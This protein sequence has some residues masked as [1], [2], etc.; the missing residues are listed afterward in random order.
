MSLNPFPNALS[1]LA[2]CFYAIKVLEMLTLLFIDAMICVIIE[3]LKFL[4]SSESK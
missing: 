2:L 3:N 4:E 1:S